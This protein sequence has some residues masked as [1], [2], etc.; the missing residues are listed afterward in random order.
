MDLKQYWGV[1]RFNHYCTPIPHKWGDFIIT[2]VPTVLV[3]LPS[4]KLDL[5]AVFASDATR[6]CN[7]H[8][9]LLQ[10]VL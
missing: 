3:C 1:R 4:T 10:A 8:P 6:I 7:S 5:E 2:G 9:T